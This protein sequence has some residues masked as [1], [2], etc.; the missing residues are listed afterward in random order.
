MPADVRAVAETGRVADIDGVVR[1]PGK[2][3]L[4]EASSAEV[5]AVAITLATTTG[6]KDQDGK[7]TSIEWV[8]IITL[9]NGLSTSNS[10]N[11]T[12]A[13]VTVTIRRRS[14][15]GNIV[16]FGKGGID[17]FEIGGVTVDEGVCGDEASNESEGSKDSGEAHDD[18]GWRMKD[19]TE[20]PVRMSRGLRKR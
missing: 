7:S 4:V 1:V 9:R 13:F 18:E 2:V 6:A 5:I 19:E 11:F 14:T 8:I 17:T 12:T 16:I 3:A 20:R 15:R 10:N